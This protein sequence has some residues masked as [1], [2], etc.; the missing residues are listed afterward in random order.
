[1]AEAEK[2]FRWAIPTLLHWSLSKH[3]NVPAVDPAVLS[4][5]GDRLVF[6]SENILK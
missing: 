4:K 3:E 2:S 1:M 5:H 6:D